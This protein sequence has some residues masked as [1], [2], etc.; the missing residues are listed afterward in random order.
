MLNSVC[1]LWCLEP[2]PWLL[3]VPDGE[4]MLQIHF[5]FGSN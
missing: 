4:C 5:A 2:F 3:L 1:A